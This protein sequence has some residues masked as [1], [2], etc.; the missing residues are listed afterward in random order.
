MKITLTA[1]K[2]DIG[3]IG[4]HIQPS[5]RVLEAV[6]GHVRQ[7]QKGLLIDWHVSYTGDDI[8]ILCTHTGGVCHE[9]VHKLAWDASRPERTWPR[10]RAFTERDR[11]F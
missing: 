8:A 3:S 10:T 5:R 7:H 6:I 4:G 9:G 2:A 11:I 1:I